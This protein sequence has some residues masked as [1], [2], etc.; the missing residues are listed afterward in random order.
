LQLG[1]TLPILF[2]TI[3]LFTVVATAALPLARSLLYTCTEQKV[4]DKWIYHSLLQVLHVPKEG[5]DYE[6]A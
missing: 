4:V 3:K 2:C 5:T 1:G 6:D